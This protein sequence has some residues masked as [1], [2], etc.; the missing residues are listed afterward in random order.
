MWRTRMWRTPMQL[1]RKQRTRMQLTPDQ[2]SRM[3][4]TQDQLSGRWFA[5]TWLFAQPWSLTRA[6][7]GV[8]FRRG[9]QY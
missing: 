8:R 9:R 6:D 4:P 7:T 2:L 5:R 1:T 3:Q